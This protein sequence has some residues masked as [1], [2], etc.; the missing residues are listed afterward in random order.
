MLC[1]PHGLLWVLTVLCL[2]L[3]SIADVKGIGNSKHVHEGH[4]QVLKALLDY[5]I[6]ANSQ[7][8]VNEIEIISI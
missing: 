3:F 4:E 7:V 1:I 2:F 8:Q 5:C 6:T